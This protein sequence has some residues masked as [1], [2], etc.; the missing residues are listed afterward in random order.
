MKSD[1][2]QTTCMRKKNTPLEPKR[3]QEILIMLTFPI[4]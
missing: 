3:Q 4:M 2:I 1:D